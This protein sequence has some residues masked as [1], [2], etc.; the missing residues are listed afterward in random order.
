MIV[1]SIFTDEHDLFRTS[2]RRF[3]EQEVT[4]NVLDW[5]R[6]GRLPRQLFERAGELGFLGIRLSPDFGGSGL[7]FRHTAIFVEELVRSASI[8]VAVSLLAHA[9]FA[10]KVIDRAG[11]D[12]LKT[13]FVAPAAAG[14]LIGALGVTEPGAGSDVGRDA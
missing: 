1:S 4:P 11:S 3:V 5:E 6:A 7:D 2:V 13:R 9:E 8:G 10:T 14:T 12:D